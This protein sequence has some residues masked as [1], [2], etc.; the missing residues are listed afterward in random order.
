MLDSNFDIAD[1]A[2]FGSGA[3]GILVFFG[4]KLISVLKREQVDQGAS[5]AATVQ[6]DL[7][8]ESLKSMSNDL[9]ELRS[10]FHK[11]DRKVHI[12]QRTITRLEVALRKLT[13]LL[14]EHNISIPMPLVEEIDDLL[15]E[16]N[17]NR[18]ATDNQG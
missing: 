5:S 9:T 16:D 8:K 18:R 6:I 1:K 13:G 4:M 14:Q 10:E 17:L 3:L 7:L 11:M 15:K 2:V 12:Q